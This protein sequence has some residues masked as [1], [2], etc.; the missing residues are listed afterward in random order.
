VKLSHI[1][2]AERQASA[3]QQRRCLLPGERQVAGADLQD[4]AFRT[5]PPDPQRRLGLASTSGEPPGT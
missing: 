3:A 5:Q 2:V 1:I 4:P